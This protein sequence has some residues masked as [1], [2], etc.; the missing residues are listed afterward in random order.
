MRNCYD[1]NKDGAGLAWAD[2]DGL[3]VKKGY[4]DWNELWKD[5]RELRPYPTLLHC[6]LA[7]HGSVSVDNC[8]PFLL[9][10]GVA[11]AHN[12]IIHTELLAKDMTD[13]ESFVIK[14]IEPW[15][16]DELRSDRV[17]SLLE[18]AVGAT[19]IIAMLSGDG[20]ILL[21]NGEHGED[22][23]DVWF[24]NDSYL[25]DYRSYAWKNYHAPLRASLRSGAAA[26]SQADCDY[27]DGKDCGLTGAP[28]RGACL[29][30]E[31]S[32]GASVPGCA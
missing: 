10:N 32:L 29:S 1:N 2:E 24:S 21:L 5:M 7:T 15:T 14:H 31:Q 22:F 8:H 30:Y 25:R 12:G 26:S 3:H 23:E 28:C 16:W 13:S 9:S 6:R 11:A 18:A 17:T 20:Q 27:Y 4:F 19:N